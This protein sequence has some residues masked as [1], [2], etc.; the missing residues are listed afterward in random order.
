[1]SQPI[2][3][4]PGHM[5]KAKREAKEKLNLVDIV[6]ELVDARIPES[7]RNPLIDEIVGN[8]PRIMVLNKADLADP[9]KTQA[10]I[11]YYQSQGI[12][13]LAIDAQHGKGLKQLE[14]QCQALM[15]DYFAKQ[16]AKGVKPRA[17]RL[18]ILGIPNVGK[19]TLINR[20]VGKNQ[21]ITG[22]K[23]G[24]TKAQRWLKVG[25]NFELLDTP[26]ILWPKFDDPLVGKKLALTG[27]IKDQLVHMD[28]LAR[29]LHISKRTLYEN[30]SSKQEIVKNAIL[31]VMD[32]LYTHHVKLIED[33]S[34]T[35]EE[36][37]LTY[38]D[39]R[40][41][42]VEIISLRQYEAILR[43][44]PEIAPELAEASKRDWD[45]LLNFLQDVA[46]SDEYKDFYVFAL[47]HMLMGAATNILNH[48][49]ELEDDKY[50]SYPK[51]MEECMR[52]VLYGI[53]K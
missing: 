34:K 1:M 45:L 33:E 22:N 13:A 39:A 23:P 47:L 35:V 31:S 19:S 48:L 36:K 11:N 16:A 32:D 10:W 18:M 17:I 30:F 28:D 29:R 2:Q 8:K 44:M 46:Q 53:K 41:E 43:K 4:F 21:A 37:L 27:A 50:Y 51:Y 25:R 42:M 52:I 12:Q 38:F 9:A 3:W 40:S 15:S 14:K 20:F 26:G 24:V 49:D 7:S 6:I 5:A